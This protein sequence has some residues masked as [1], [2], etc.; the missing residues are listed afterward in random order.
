[1]KVNIF[2]L[3]ILCCLFPSLTIAHGVTG[4]IDAGGVVITALFSDGEPM[5]YAETEIMAPDSKL[6]FSSGWTDRNGRFCFYPDVQGSY[7]VTVKD[8]MGHRLE[9]N[10]PI[11]DTLKYKKDI[12]KTS[13][14]SNVSYLEKAFL[15]LS[16]IFFVFGFAFWKSATKAKNPGHKV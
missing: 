5:S 8:E 15:G 7:K 10:V 6:P 4:N 1:M 2:V 11:T 14:S 13:E 16:A 9:L 12:K 3:L